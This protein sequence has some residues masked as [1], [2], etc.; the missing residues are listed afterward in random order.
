MVQSS[1]LVKNVYE[2][3]LAYMVSAGTAYSLT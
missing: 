3:E 1:V 2:E